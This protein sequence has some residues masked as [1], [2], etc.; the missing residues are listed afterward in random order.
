M[1]RGG[2]GKQR[3]AG[4]RPS[5]RGGDDRGQRKPGGPMEK[6]GRAHLGTAIN[7]TKRHFKLGFETPA[8]MIHQGKD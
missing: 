6:N 2:I 7:Q 4:D 8:G 3:K 1:P 5:N